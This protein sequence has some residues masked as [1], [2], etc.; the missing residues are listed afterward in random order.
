MANE[1]LFPDQEPAYDFDRDLLVFQAVADGKSVE[2]V[3]TAELLIARFGAHDP[4][5]T[6]LRGAY[7]EHLAE[8]QD[9]ARGHIQHGWIDDE[10][11]V[12]LTRRYTRLTVDYDKGLR[13]WPEGLALAEALEPGLIEL[14]GPN[15]GAVDLL[16]GVSGDPDKDKRAIILRLVDPEM[17]LVVSEGIGG[18]IPGKEKE[19]AKS[20]SILL[21]KVWANFLRKRSWRLSLKSG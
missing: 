18:V 20:L 15:A 17:S 1:I 8:I 16:W 4:S 7:R 11:R 9:I 6:S 14:I 2:C 19:Q 10:R 12:F 3:V 21:G 5:P 13:L